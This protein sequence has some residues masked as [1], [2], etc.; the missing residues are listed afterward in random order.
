MVY[1]FM[2]ALSKQFLAFSFYNLTYSKL[3]KH[4]EEKKKKFSKYQNF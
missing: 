1:Y 2:K 4:N 3:N